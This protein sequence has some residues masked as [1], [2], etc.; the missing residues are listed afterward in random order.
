MKDD[1]SGR[2][3]GVVLAAGTS[4]RMGKNKLFLPLGGKS[5]LRRAV[6]TA[7]GAGLDPVLVVLGHE[8]DRAAAELADLSFTKVFNA[9]Y[10]WS[11]P[12]METCSL[13]PSSTAAPSSASCARWTATDAASAW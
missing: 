5:V 12:R 7:A 8:S 4:S 10:A 1:R 9:E 6:G 13:H 2:I 3:A 11:S